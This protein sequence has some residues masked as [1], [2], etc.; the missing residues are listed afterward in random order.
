MIT[1][2]LDVFGYAKVRRL[3]RDLIAEYQALVDQA[4]ARLTESNVDAVVDLVSL[5]D[6]V[7]GYQDVKLANVDKFRERA[8]AAL[9][10]L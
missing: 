10:A 8:K 5:Y 1:C 2:T 4:V 7:R 6:V 9:A 3:E